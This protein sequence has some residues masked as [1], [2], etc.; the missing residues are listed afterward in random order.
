MSD[1]RA[2]VFRALARARGRASPVDN[3]REELEAIGLPPTPAMDADSALEA[4]LIRLTQAKATVEIAAD[5]T[6]VVK[7]IS[8]Y[9]YRRHNSR[10]IVA[11]HDPRL[12]ALPWRDGGVLVR[13]DAAE[14]E[15][16][17]SVSYAGLG[18]AESGSVLLYS[19]RGNPARN[20][21]LVQEQIVVLDLDDLQENFEQAWLRIG[22]DRE[23]GICPRAIHFISGPSS[24][25]D[26]VGHL[27][28][29]AHGPLALHVILRG[30]VEPQQQES[31]A[32]YLQ[33]PY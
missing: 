7:S 13:F 2:E 29:G 8:N 19:D 27:V 4:F 30:H 25:G 18:V 17:V 9:L 14:A 6:Q 24:T 26:I 1:S 11:G 12:A 5:R 16:T 10:R 33:L 20:N 32:Q 23:A 15:D 21:W 22:A 28:V 31:L 3:I